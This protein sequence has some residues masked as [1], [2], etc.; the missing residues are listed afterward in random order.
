M[1]IFLQISPLILMK[2]CMLPEYVGLL[3]SILNLFCMIDI[4]GI[5]PFFGDSVTRKHK[6]TN[7]PISCKFG[8]MMESTQVLKTTGWSQLNSRRQGGVN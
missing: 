8:M 2:F 7:N 3:K 1:L 6:Q 5:K 4:P